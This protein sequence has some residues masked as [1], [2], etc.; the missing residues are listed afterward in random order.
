MQGTYSSSMAEGLIEHVAV[1]KV[2]VMWMTQVYSDKTNFRAS[3]PPEE[4]PWEVLKLLA[5]FS[6]TWWTLSDRTIF[7]PPGVLLDDGT[8]ERT[9]AS[10][11]VEVVAMS[12]SVSVRWQDGRLATEVP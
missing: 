11:L 4:C 1:G 5:S 7:N 6:H 2:N 8:E 9:T 3:P 10:E 12:T